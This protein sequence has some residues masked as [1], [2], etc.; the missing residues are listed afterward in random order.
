MCHLPSIL[1]FLAGALPIRSASAATLLIACMRWSHVSDYRGMQQVF[2]YLASLQLLWSS[3]RTSAPACLTGLLFGAAYWVAPLGLQQ[4]KVRPAEPCPQLPDQIF[5]M[6]RAY[7]SACQLK[8][9][10]SNLQIPPV[11]AHWLQGAA[12]PQRRP[13]QPAQ[14]PHRPASTQQQPS[15]QAPVSVP[16]PFHLII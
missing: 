16:T 8:Q 10:L 14:G 9:D 15:S 11:V 13:G 6:S 4:I 5:I 1:S 3:P 2:I 7:S 12:R